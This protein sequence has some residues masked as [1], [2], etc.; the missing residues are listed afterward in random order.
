MRTALR[1]IT[2]LL[3]LVLASSS[4]GQAGSLD[5]TFDGDGV[6]TLDIAA[7]YD[8]GQAVAVQPDGRIVMAG[9]A[10]NT[11]VLARFMPDGF[12]DMGFGTDGVVTVPGTSAYAMVLQPDGR[13]VVSGAQNTAGEVDAMIMRFHADGAPDDSFGTNGRVLVGS[14]VTAEYL[15]GLALQPDGRIVAVGSKCG[16]F[17]QCEFLVARVLTD[18]TPDPS[19][20]NGGSTTV[21]M[22]P[23]EERG[24]GIALRPDGRM[25]ITGQYGPQQGPGLAVIALQADGGLDMNAM[26]ALPYGIGPSWSYTVRVLPS[27]GFLLAGAV[28]NGLQNDFALVRFAADGWPDPTFGNEGVVL[29]DFGGSTDN[30]ITVVEQPDGKLIQVGTTIDAQFGRSIAIARFNADGTL[31]PTFDGDGKVVTDLGGDDMAFD[32]ALQADGKLVITGYTMMQGEEDLMVARYLTGLEVGMEEHG[33][34]AP[35]LIRRDGDAVR[36]SLGAHEDVALSILDTTGRVCVDR[37][38]NGS[39]VWFIA[40]APGVYLARAQGQAGMRTV[41]FAV[42]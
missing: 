15:E 26:P 11:L 24:Y 38:W 1:S 17:P 41:R 14:S 42:E 22:T 37:S 39:P 5:V 27:G 4:F 16:D 33:A 29:T 30:S 2:G 40:P 35:L 31:D 10:Y 28:F 13:I 25:L 36:L 23:D 12:L 9:Y 3:L 20:D 7:V 6:T 32:A 21:D 8:Y 19:F 18:G 34:D